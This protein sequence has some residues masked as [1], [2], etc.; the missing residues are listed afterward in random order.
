MVN[1]LGSWLP[2]RE[3]G[4]Y[5]GTGKSLTIWI[6]LAT[7]TV[8]VFYGYDQGVFGNVIVGQH[9]LDTMGNPSA[10]LLGTMA[11]VYTLGCF[12]GAVSTIWT[13][14]LL[15]RPRTILVG[16]AVV[17]IGAILQA[18]AYGVQQMIVGRIIVGLG[19]GMNTATAG[20]WQS[21]TSKPQSRGK[22][23]MIHMA[24][25]ISG[26]SFS[27]WL[28]LGF[29]FAPGS[30]AWRFP[31]AFQI[32]FA[33]ALFCMC[34]W[35]PESPRL[36]IRKGRDDEA[37]E[38]LAAMEG[39]G[40]TRDTPSVQLQF[41][42]IKDVLDREHVNTYSWWTLLRGNGPAGVLRRMA[43]GAGMQAMNQISGINA[44]S[45]YTTYIFINAL[46]IGETHARILAAAG[47]VNYLIFALLSFLPIERYG[48]RRVFMTSSA[49]CSACFLAITIALYL[50][51]SG[52]RNTF[53]MGIVA[54]CFF[55]IFWSAFGAGALGIPW[56]YASEI[57]A[58][59]MRTKGASVAMST[60]WIVNYAVVQVTTDGI[61]NLHWRFWIIWTIIC[62]SFVPIT[63]LFYPET[64]NR[65][66]ED[67]DRFFE[68]KPRVILCNNRL[69]TQR[70]RPVE[71]EE[72]DKI[73]QEQT[74]KDNS[75]E[76][77]SVVVVEHKELGGH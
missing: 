4:R 16:S 3:K 10:S 13:G 26:F 33:L 56:L 39:N 7:S 50:S 35:L 70:E 46:G 17:T 30:V 25:C 57:N 72:A 65:S 53:D 5:L 68:T 15:G 69:A 44:T 29:S 6:S 9:F 75:S 24:Q 36:L 31:L 23:V 37:I 28:T 18:S 64:A 63:Y 77:H 76:K 66:L 43:L 32:V 71:F 45:Y 59:E 19:I 42:I 27:N 41:N 8:L 1:I 34:P 67:I 22:L 52:K 49:V 48:R 14:D 60:N 58:L 11:S 38:V 62:A 55:F 61:N 2:A 21:E 47:S 73:V 51:D 74:A 12:F 20:V 40:A 54:V